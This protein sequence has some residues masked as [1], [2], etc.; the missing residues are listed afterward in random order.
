MAPNEEFGT[1]RQ[2][3]LGTAKKTSGGLRKNDLFKKGGRIKSVKVSKIAKEQ[4][5]KKL[6]KYLQMKGSGLF[7][8]RV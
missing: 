8:P 1:R 5:K 7:G 4:A 2:V 6:G 3:W